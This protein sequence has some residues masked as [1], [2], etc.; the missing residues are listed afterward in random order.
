MVKIQE[1]DRRHPQRPLARATTV[2]GTVCGVL[3]TLVVTSPIA[4]AAETTWQIAGVSPG[5]ARSAY[6]SSP[7]SGGVCVTANDRWTDQVDSRIRTIAFTND[8]FCTGGP[9]QTCDGFVPASQAIPLFDVMS[10]RWVG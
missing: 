5:R 1:P 8:S 2:F 6:V 9:M 3:T 7:S 4:S 10:C